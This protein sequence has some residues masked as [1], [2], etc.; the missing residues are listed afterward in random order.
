MKIYVEG[1]EIETKEII[2]IRDAGECYGFVIYL[3]GGRLLNI[4]QGKDHRITSEENE[5]IKQKHNALKDK[6]IEKWN[7]DKTDFIVLNL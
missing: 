5:I 4:I 2:Q 6:V 1:K 3:T 7:E